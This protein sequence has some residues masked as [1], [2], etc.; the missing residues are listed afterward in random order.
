MIK[1]QLKNNLSKICTQGLMNVLIK[2]MALCLQKN[3]MSMTFIKTLLDVTSNVLIMIFGKIITL[4][5]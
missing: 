4:K 1:L 2:H 3:K 5:N